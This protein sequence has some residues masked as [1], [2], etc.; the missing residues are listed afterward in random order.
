[1][2]PIL[3]NILKNYSKQI[4][5]PVDFALKGKKRK[6]ILLNDAPFYKKIFDVGKQSVELFKQELHNVDVI[7]MKGPLGFS[8]FRE[9][10]YGTVEILEEISRLTK[11][12]KIFSL[13]GGG[14]LTT[15]IEHYH[16]PRTFSYVSNSGG[17]LIAYV[18]GENLPGIA[19][20]EKL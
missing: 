4:V 17:A 5:L 12:K 18:A 3:K 10:K 7:F 1:L 11:Q 20:L 19:A 14:H 15:T 2:S 16:L 8:E 6:E 13:L 9:F